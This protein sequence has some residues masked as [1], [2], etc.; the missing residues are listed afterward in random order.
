MSLIG[1]LDFLLLVKKI[2]SKWMAV[3]VGMRVSWTIVSTFIGQMY[4]LTQKNFMQKLYLRQALKTRNNETRTESIPGRG[5]EWVPHSLVEMMGTG[6][7][8]TSM[9]TARKARG[10]VVCS[11]AEVPKPLRPCDIVLSLKQYRKPLRVLSKR[12]T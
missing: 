9:A 2:F 5:K 12:V 10:D 7:S 3:L 11:E 8:R 4:K 1:G 6:T